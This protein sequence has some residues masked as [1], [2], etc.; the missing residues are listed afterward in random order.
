VPV[1]RQSRST[2]GI[3]VEL[4]GCVIIRTHEDL[5]PTP[6]TKLGESRQARR[7]AR[8]SQRSAPTDVLHGMNTA[9]NAPSV[10][11]A[12]WAGSSRNPYWRLFATISIPASPRTIARP[13]TSTVMTGSRG[14]STSRRTGST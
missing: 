7:P 10:M 4:E 9:S 12:R 6:V 2:R 8:P 11:D 13:S 5:S 1:L 14:C 3:T